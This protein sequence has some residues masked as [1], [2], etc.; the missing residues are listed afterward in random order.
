MSLTAKLAGAAKSYSKWGNLVGQTKS[1]VKVYEKVLNGGSRRVL[2]SFDADGFLLK[3]TVID[4]TRGG[5]K[6]QVFNGHDKL[7]R[8]SEHNHI[9]TFTTTKY[10]KDGNIAEQLFANFKPDN[11]HVRLQLNSGDKAVRMVYHPAIADKH[12]K[13]TVNCGDNA[14]NDPI[15]LIDD[16]ELPMG[17]FDVKNLPEHG[18]ALFSNSYSTCKN[19]EFAEILYK[20]FNKIFKIIEK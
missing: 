15:K 13:F 4:K 12:P 2:G 11:K 5:H 17:T 19:R 9:G 10:D 8:F 16:I 14:I 6:T 3:K 1:G 20:Q 18:E 7:V